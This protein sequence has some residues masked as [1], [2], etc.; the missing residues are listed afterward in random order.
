[1]EK[2]Y[3]DTIRCAEYSESEAYNNS[4]GDYPHYDDYDNEDY[5]M[6]SPHDYFD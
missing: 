4:Y 2:F 1:M 3:W 6:E 5:D